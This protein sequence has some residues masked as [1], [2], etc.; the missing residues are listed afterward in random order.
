LSKFDYYPTIPV[1]D[2]LYLASKEEKDLTFFI[3]ITQSAKRLLKLTL[4]FQEDDANIGL[5]RVDFNGRHHNPETANDKV[6]MMLKKHTGEWIEE[7]HI[8]YF[9]E[10][11]K[12][13]AWAIPLNDDNSFA[14]KS[15]NDIYD[16]GNVL[17]EFGRKINLQTQIRTTI[18]TVIA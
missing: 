5:L 10:G 4:H 7:S 1:S 15:F 8:H 17:G 11:Y 14:V 18:Q 16:I 9:V 2:R 3:E 6:P 13:L 12:P